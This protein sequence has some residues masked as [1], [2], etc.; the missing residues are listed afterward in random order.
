[1]LLPKE[2]GR[3]G[4]G[5]LAARTDSAIRE[6]STRGQGSKGGRKESKRCD[7]GRSEAEDTK[8]QDEG[9]R[10]HKLPEDDDSGKLLN[11]MQG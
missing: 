5:E 6:E 3:P 9:A 8:G 1:M 11:V 10:E 7:G 2:Q 4:E